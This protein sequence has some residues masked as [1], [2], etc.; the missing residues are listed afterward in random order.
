MPAT[1]RSHPTSMAYPSFVDPPDSVRSAGHL[2]EGLLGCRLLLPQP[3]PV[4]HRLDSGWRTDSRIP[5]YHKTC[6]PLLT[7]QGWQYRRYPKFCPGANGLACVGS[8]QR[9]ILPIPGYPRKNPGSKVDRR[10]EGSGLVGSGSDPRRKDGNGMQRSG[11]ALI[12]VKLLIKQK[13]VA[14]AAKER[15]KS[16]LQRQKLL[17][18]FRWRHADERFKLLVEVR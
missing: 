7:A 3:K 11:Q 8:I 15:K 18:V 13:F 4:P 2:R 9:P 5:R 17:P 12:F 14:S 1:D 16:P 10:S 6:L